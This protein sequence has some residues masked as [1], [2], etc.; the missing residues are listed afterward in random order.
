MLLYSYTRYFISWYN[1]L[2]IKQ[3]CRYY[4]IYKLPRAVQKQ[5]LKQYI[6]FAQMHN[7][8]F[9][10]FEQKNWNECDNT[11]HS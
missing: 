10:F 8:I 1:I 4:R 5:I 2:V 11:I 7:P 3:L 9:H 6:I